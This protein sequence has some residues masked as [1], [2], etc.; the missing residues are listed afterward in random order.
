MSKTTKITAAL[1]ASTLTLGLVVQADAQGRPP[2]RAHT[3]TEAQDLSLA[4][5]TQTKSG[6]T[7]S[8]TVRGNKRIIASNG[9][10]E[11]QVGR[12]PSRGNPNRI[13]SQNYRF[14]MPTNPRLRNSPTQQRGVLFGVAVNGVPFDPGTAEVWK[15]NR[16]SGWN[17][18]AL[19]GAIP[20][21]LDANYGHVQPT[22]AYHYHGLP[23]GL[24]QELGWSKSKAS[25]L[26]GYAADGF[27]IYAI[28]AE[29]NGKVV[30]M[31]S[32]YRLKSGN[33]PG[34][35][36]PSGDYDGTF[37]QD[38]VYVEGAGTLDECNGAMVTTA[39]Y[40]NGTYAYFL[41]NDFPVIPRCH[42]GSPDSS[43]SKRRR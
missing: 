25:P 34:G 40:P 17:Y 29:V 32:S 8:I 15:G 22:G 38:Y 18:E 31:T 16:R 13:S 14:S 24:M 9:I 35:S 6:G 20:L 3:A 1:V 30:E 7:V 43:F 12:F 41:T 21:G 4:R 42:M 33:R 19:G 26:I 5:A 37:V 10:P 36:Q 39:E 23:V 11:H 2:A 28:T 27:P